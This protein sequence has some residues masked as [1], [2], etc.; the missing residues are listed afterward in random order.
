MMIESIYSDWMGETQRD[1]IRQ[2]LKKVEASG[3][4]LDVGA[5]PGFLE[6]FIDGVVAVDVDIDNLK[7]SNGTKILAD[8]N[9]LPFPEKSF[10]TIF[11][12]DSIHLIENTDDIEGVLKD[13]GKL[14]VTLFCNKYNSR[15][16]LEYL[17]SLF[18]LDV[19]KEFVV[20][21]EK[22]WDAVVVFR[23]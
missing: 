16:R 14:I 23:K 6:E 8:G 11:C 22:E 1:K 4:V 19:E 18:S 21:T 15:E 3:R 10:D 7:K 20:E 5:G 13:G 9:R 17:K 12:I 2:I